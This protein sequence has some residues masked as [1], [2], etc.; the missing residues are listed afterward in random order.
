MLSRARWRG[1]TKHSH[2]R[3]SG[4]VITECLVN[5]LKK[6]QA[7]RSQNPVGF[8]PRVGSIPTSGTTQPADA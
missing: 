5:Q 8:T 6:Q 7:Y 3:S 4:A 2:A 1:T